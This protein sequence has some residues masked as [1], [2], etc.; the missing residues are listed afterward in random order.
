MQ[1]DELVVG[2][3]HSKAWLG[4]V[5]CDATIYFLR[6]QTDGNPPVPISAM[7]SDCAGLCPPPK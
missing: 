7:S 6:M 5:L 4:K 3:H 2:Q 1:A